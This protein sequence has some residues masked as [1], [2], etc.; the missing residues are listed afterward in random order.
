MVPLPQVVMGGR[1]DITPKNIQGQHSEK[2]TNKVEQGLWH[3]S[4]HTQQS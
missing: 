4:K 3:L 2:N 1:A